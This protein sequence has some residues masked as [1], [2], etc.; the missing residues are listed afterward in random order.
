M[1]VKYTQLVVDIAD[2]PGQIILLR[3]QLPRSLVAMQTREQHLL[4]RI[5][6]CGKQIQVGASISLA[7]DSQYLA[8]DFYVDLRRRRQFL[9]MGFDFRPVLDEHEAAITRSSQ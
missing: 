1:H 6:L 7:N 9:S 4:K 8:F 2:S 3:I 5:D